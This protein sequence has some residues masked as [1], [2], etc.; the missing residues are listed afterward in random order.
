MIDIKKH[1]DYWKETA[2]SDIDTATLLIEKGKVKEGLF[3]SHLFLEKILKAHFVRKNN[4]IAPK[5]HDLVYLINK[6]EI[7]LNTD[8]LQLVL[9]IQKFQLEGRYPDYNISIPPIE[10]A[11]KLL[12]K[13]KEL[14]LWLLNQL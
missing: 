4:N 7:E 3:F 5:T 8:F 14:Y 1:I 9:T 13:S 2:S 12:N 6:S 11:T 10:D